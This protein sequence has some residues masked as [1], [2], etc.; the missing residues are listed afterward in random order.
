MVL[1]P[2]PRTILAVALVVVAGIW[3]LVNGPVE[4]P[5]MVVVTPDHG[6]SVADLFSL[7][8]LAVA[9]VLLLTSRR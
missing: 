7:L 8:A 2:R 6:L 1:A 4:G 5:T 3:V 9:A